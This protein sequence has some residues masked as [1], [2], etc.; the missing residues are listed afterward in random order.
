ML[1][2]LAQLRATARNAAWTAVS[3]ALRNRDR[4]FFVSGAGPRIFSPSSRRCLAISRPASALPI[5]ACV[6]CL[7]VGETAR[8]HFETARCQRNIR[9]HTDVDSR[10]ALRNP[11]VGRV[12]TVTDENHPHVRGHGW[13]DWSRAIGDHKNIELKARRN[14][15]DLLAYR[16]RITIQVN[17]GHVSAQL[18]AEPRFAAS[19]TGLLGRPPLINHSRSFDHRHRVRA[20]LTAIASAFRCPTSTT[21]RLPRVTPV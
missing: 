13:T 2:K 15:V 21:R 12:C 7:P 11:I 3:S 19:R 5:F 10:D 17:V 16:T 8:P 14:A 20:P 1:P 18:P 9:G 6:Q 4:S